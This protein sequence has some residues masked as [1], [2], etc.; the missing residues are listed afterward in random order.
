MIYRRRKARGILSHQ[1]PNNNFPRSKIQ[2]EQSSLDNPSAKPDNLDERQN[3]SVE[4]DQHIMEF[5][6][7]GFHF[8][9]LE[10]KLDE[11]KAEIEWESGSNTATVWKKANSGFVKKWANSCQVVMVEF[12]NRFEKFFVPLGESVQAAISAALPRL[13]EMISPEKA[14]LKH[15]HGKR[16]PGVVC[17][18]EDRENVSQS[19]NEFLEI[20]KKEEIRKRFKKETVTGISQ[21]RLQLLEKIGFV[22]KLKDKYSDVEVI[23]DLEKREF[24]F[25]GPHEQFTDAKIT[26]LD[27]MKAISEQTLGLPSC[28]LVDI[29]ASEP[30]K[31]YIRERLALEE[32][33]VIVLPQDGNTLKIVAK[34]SI[35]YGRARGCICDLM[36]QINIPFPRGHEFIFTK[37][38]WKQLSKQLKSQQLINLNINLTRSSIVLHG[39]ADIAY[40]SKKKIS[41]YVESQ[42]IK[43]K[44]LEVS[45]GVARFLGQHLSDEVENIKRELKDDQMSVEINKA[46]GVILLKGTEGGLKECTRD[47]TRLCRLVTE[48][49]IEFFFPGS[50]QLFFHDRGKRY[51]KLI[52][53]EERVIIVMTKESKK[54]MKET[55]GRDAESFRKELEREKEKKM[56]F[57]GDHRQ[58]VIHPKTM[59]STYD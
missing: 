17:L 32:I 45:Q 2:E 7:S 37:E 57:W 35:E 25:E 13:A 27:T 43:E 8:K 44:K 12:L 19:V 38:R 15:V 52:E 30:G 16:K 29:I 42:I 58:S 53:A 24:Y 59:G 49:K 55:L 41:E 36:C 20:I 33:D 54:G 40:E 39:V 31:T 48:N 9:E 26:Y 1:I 18:E 21:H 23:L 11:V 51:M 10:D 6:I 47:I 4:V 56:P 34:N 3:T 14:L 46:P 28:I 50:S 5:I 22:E